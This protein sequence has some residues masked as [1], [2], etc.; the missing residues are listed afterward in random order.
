LNWFNRFFWRSVANPFGLEL[1]QYRFLFLFVQIFQSMN[2]FRGRAFV[3]SSKGVWTD[4]KA[5]KSSPKKL[6]NFKLVQ[7][8]IVQKMFF[9]ILAQKFFG[10]VQRRITRYIAWYVSTDY[11]VLFGPRTANPGLGQGGVHVLVLQAIRASP[12]I[13]RTPYS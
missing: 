11:A 6:K 7:I 1:V 4:L 3:L 9:N 13:I 2:E 8:L 5:A 10:P 12:K